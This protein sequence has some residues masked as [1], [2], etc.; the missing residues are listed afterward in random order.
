MV[1]LAVPE[2]EAGDGEENREGGGDDR[3]DFLTGVEAALRC[4]AAAEPGEVVCVEA[5]DLAR[6]CEQSAA[7]TGEDDECE[8]S[9]PGERRVDVDVFQQGTS[10]GSARQG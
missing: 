3:V 5:V 4:A 1:A 6:G 8:C 7:V 10:S 2:E 9:E